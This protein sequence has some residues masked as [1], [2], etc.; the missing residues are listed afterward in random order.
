MAVNPN[1]GYPAYPGY[2]FPAYIPAAQP[3]MQNSQGI[4]SASR[5]VG[6]KEEAVAIPTDLSGA[7][8]VFPDISHN[9]VY[10]KR[11]NP[12]TGGSDL[13]EFIPAATQTE[14]QY[15]TIEDFKAFKDELAKRLTRKGKKDDDAASE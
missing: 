10:V 11:L 13:F 9:R 8:M 1:Y 14:T 12:T 6:S 4:S 15:V 2:S 7:F 5:M 3:S